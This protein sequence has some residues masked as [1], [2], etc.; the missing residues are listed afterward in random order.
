MSATPCRITRRGPT[1]RRG[2]LRSVRGGGRRL[3]QLPKGWLTLWVPTG[4]GDTSE[5]GRSPAE[6][7]GRTPP[8]SAAGSTRSG[9][10]SGSAGL[11]AV[12]SEAMESGPADRRPVPSFGCVREVAAQAPGAVAAEWPRGRSSPATGR[13]RR[14]VG[15]RTEPG[16]CGC[17]RA[18]FGKGRSLGG[19]LFRWVRA[20]R[21]GPT[22]RDRAEARSGQSRCAARIGATAEADRGGGIAS[23][24]PSRPRRKAPTARSA[25]PGSIGEGAPRSGRSHDRR[26]RT[27]RS[28]RLEGGKPRGP[29]SRRVRADGPETMVRETEAESSVAQGTSE[30][31]CGDRRARGTV[32]PF[33]AR[34][35]GLGRSG[36]RR[37]GAPDRCEG[38]TLGDATVRECEIPG[39]ALGHG[40]LATPSGASGLQPARTRK[41]EGG[42]PH[43]VLAQRGRKL[44]LEYRAL[45]SPAFGSRLGRARSGIQPARARKRVGGGARTS[46]SRMKAVTSASGIGR[47]K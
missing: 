14:G 41:R 31:V 43:Q 22:G 28:G 13:P 1:A 15:V 8:L 30:T 47:A 32:E 34:C 39:R 33:L 46:R 19:R 10:S 37:P 7:A 9:V 6:P 38:H 17:R 3:G 45:C 5:P 40:A 35:G 44:G 16:R 42:G 2:R 12:S 11:W 26:G 18:R 27:V 24:A 25:P 29:R 20:D 36:D 21:P 4:G 23:D